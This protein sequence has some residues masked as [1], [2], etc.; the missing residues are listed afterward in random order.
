MFP[1]LNFLP[2]QMFMP[3]QKI[4]TFPTSDISEITL[5]IDKRGSQN[6]ERAVIEPWKIA[7]GIKAKMQ[8]LPNVDAIIITIRKSSIAFAKSVLSLENIR[9]LVEMQKKTYGNQR[10]YDYFC[11]EFEN[12]LQFVFN[13]KE[14]LDNVGNDVSDEKVMLRNTIVTISHKLYL[15]QCFVVLEKELR[16]ENEH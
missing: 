6:F 3:T 11:E 8:P 16:E 1:T 15:D 2:K 4:S 5:P 10:A 12:I 9:M 13:L 7:M 14:T